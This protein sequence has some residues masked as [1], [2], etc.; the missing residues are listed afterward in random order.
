M[1]FMDLR[2]CLRFRAQNWVA[3][4]R[5][6]VVIST[7]PPSKYFGSQVLSINMDSYTNDWTVISVFNNARIDSKKMNLPLQGLRSYVHRS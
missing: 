1:F 3:I 7:Y 6:A 4:P 5:V 2:F